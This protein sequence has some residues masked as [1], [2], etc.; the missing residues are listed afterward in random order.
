MI[1][2]RNQV[3]LIYIVTDFSHFSKTFDKVDRDTLSDWI[4]SYHIPN[5]SDSINLQRDL[6]L[7]LTYSYSILNSIRKHFFFIAKI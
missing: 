6:D 1:E 3:E 7:L 5:S 4:K 2:F